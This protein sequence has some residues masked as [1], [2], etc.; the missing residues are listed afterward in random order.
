MNVHSTYSSPKSAT[1][2]NNRDL[3]NNAVTDT[4]T[5]EIEN[6]FLN[7]KQTPTEYEIRLKKA[8]QQLLRYPCSVI[9]TLSLVNKIDRDA[10]NFLVD[11]CLLLFT[12]NL[13]EAHSQMDPEGYV[14]YMPNTIDLIFINR[15]L[16]YEVDPTLYFQDISIPE[17]W[18]SYLSINGM[19]LLRTMTLYRKILESTASTASSVNVQRKNLQTTDQNENISL[20]LHAES[21][22]EQSQNCESF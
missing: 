9:S 7:V 2:D 12:D 18:T 19:I 1:G 13:F 15:L 3:D 6:M 21:L 14:K 17:L 11:D 8:C 22:D 10:A 4:N 16:H 20:T 5:Q